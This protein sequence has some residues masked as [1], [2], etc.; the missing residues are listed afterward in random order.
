MTEEQKAER[1]TLI[2][3]NKAWASAETVRRE[4]LTTPL[5]RKTL[6]K[7]TPVMI[8]TG[9]T[10]HRHA[11]SSATR[12]DNELAHHLPG[13]EKTG[14]FEA[15]KLAALIEKS[16]AKAKDVALAIVL[17]ACESVTS[18]PSWRYHQ[19]RRRLPH[20]TRHLGIQAQRRRRNHHHDSGRGAH[21]GVLN[22][23]QFS[24]AGASSLRPAPASL[25]GRPDPTPG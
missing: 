8:A 7:D 6:P 18:E 1:R 16:P 22:Q 19:R 2:A 9:L 25:P 11:V 12:D 15:D 14:Y 24:C 5:S 13:I 10:V 23:P 20:T 3:N 21:R 4:W 17:G